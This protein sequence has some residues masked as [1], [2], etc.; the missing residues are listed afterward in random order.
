MVYN[1]LNHGIGL[2]FESASEHYHTVFNIETIE[3]IPFSSVNLNSDMYKWGFII[4]T[5]Y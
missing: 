4:I 2:D 3:Q 5:N 1:N